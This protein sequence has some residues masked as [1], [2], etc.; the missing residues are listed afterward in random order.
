MIPLGDSFF[1]TIAGSAA[2]LLGLSFFALIFF[3]TE[4]FRRYEYED[5]A[6]PVHPD[7]LRKRLKILGKGRR[8]SP[9]HIT[10]LALLDGDPLV[11][12]SAFSVAVSW[13]MY[14]VSLVVSLTAV[15]GTF[16]NVWVFAGELLAFWCIL[17]FSLIVR[18]KKRSELVTYRTR[19]EHLWAAFE[20]AFV[21]IWFMGAACTFIAAFAMG[22]VIYFVD[23]KRLAFW[24]HFGIDNITMVVSILKIIS[25]GGLF[26]GLYVTN[27]DF[28]VYF[29][30]KTSDRM[31]RKWLTD[32]LRVRYPQLKET[33]NEIMVSK[34]GPDT[35][36]LKKLW[37]EGCPPVEYVRAGCS[38]LLGKPD[39]RWESLL[40]SEGRV[41]TWMFDVSG[42]A[43]WAS[44]LEQLIIQSAHKSADKE[45]PLAL[46]KSV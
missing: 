1:S 32:F 17:T 5:L 8:K 46:S 22:P 6:L 3:L 42:L 23:F 16:A 7:M 20:W 21:G 34:G 29:K 37:H 45:L 11:Y 15:S 35:K 25:L 9:E 33:I 12:F 4:L 30:S 14:F 24:S 43:L 2:A 27:K 36:E 26:F 44:A 19:D 39:A 40:A 38:P 13:N 28:F 41:A 18:N 10:D 31:R